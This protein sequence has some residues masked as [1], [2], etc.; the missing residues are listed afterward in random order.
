VRGGDL[1]PR[2]G[3]T[4]RQPID[5]FF[6]SPAAATPPKAPRFRA[7]SRPYRGRSRTSRAG[8]PTA[9]L[10]ALSLAEEWRRALWTLR[11][12]LPT[13]LRVGRAVNASGWLIGRVGRVSGSPSAPPRR[14]WKVGWCGAARALRRA[15]RARLYADG[16]GPGGSDPLVA[17]G[18]CG[19]RWGC[20]SGARSAAPRGHDFQRILAAYY[21]A[22][23][24]RLY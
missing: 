18:G 12:T 3:L 11:R 4:Y 19:A 24:S 14:W 15:L 9:D 20:A 1:H 7:A 17:D 6:Y 8:R 22:P 13:T 23:R 10:T 5:A 21:P 16:S 2:P